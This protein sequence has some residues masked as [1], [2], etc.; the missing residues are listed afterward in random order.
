MV[1][2]YRDHRADF[3]IGSEIMKTMPAARYLDEPHKDGY[4]IDHVHQYRSQALT[5]IMPV[6]LLIRPFI[7]R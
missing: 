4:S 5:Y 7:P 3:S 6:V 2:F 1:K